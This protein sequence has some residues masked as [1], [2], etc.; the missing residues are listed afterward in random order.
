MSRKQ[1]K[2]IC[3]VHEKQQSNAIKILLMVNIFD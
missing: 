3:E 2:I 1:D